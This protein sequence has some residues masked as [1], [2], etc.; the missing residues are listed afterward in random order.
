[1]DSVT[2][3]TLTSSE[4][5]Q[6]GAVLPTV[7]ASVATTD[8]NFTLIYRC[9]D[10]SLQKFMQDSN[11]VPLKIAPVTPNPIFSGAKL[12]T[13]NYATRFEGRVT[14]EILDELGASVARPVVGQSMSAG[15]YR[16]SFDPSHLASGVYT[17]RISL[18]GSGTASTRF[19]V[20]K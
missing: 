13:F 6:G 19:V 1:M 5:Y 12:V 4:I 16:L 7:C 2:D 11:Y 17:A 10:A 8:S 18:E 14:F 15:E 3:I 20:Q 9:G